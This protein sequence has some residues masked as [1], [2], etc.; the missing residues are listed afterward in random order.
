MSSARKIYCTLKRDRD[1]ATLHIE[2]W[3]PDMK[4]WER[5]IVETD[6]GPEADSKSSSVATQ[7]SS[8]VLIRDLRVGAGRRVSTGPAIIEK[9]EISRRGSRGRLVR[10]GIRALAGDWLCRPSSQDNRTMPPGCLRGASKG[11]SKGGGGGGVEGSGGARRRLLSLLW[12]TPRSLHLVTSWTR[13][14]PNS[15]TLVPNK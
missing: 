7:L 13:F 5:K 11:R 10:G 4:I 14:A 1:I 6:L 15:S 12:L 3:Q 8:R 9:G 2:M